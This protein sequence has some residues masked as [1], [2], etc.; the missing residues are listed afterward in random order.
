M[1]IYVTFINFGRSKPT[2]RLL[3]MGYQTIVGSTRHDLT[4]D[5]TLIHHHQWWSLQQIVRVN[6]VTWLDENTVSEG[7]SY[8]SSI[9]LDHNKLPHSS[10]T[11]QDYCLKCSLSNLLVSNGSCNPETRLYTCTEFR[12][13]CPSKFLHFLLGL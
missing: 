7:Q 2:F 3:A 11:R 10:P 8:K 9:Y 13:Y 1:N 4:A 5:R 6:F 12:Q